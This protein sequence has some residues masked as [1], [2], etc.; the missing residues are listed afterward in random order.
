MKAQ[1]RNCFTNMERQDLQASSAN[2]KKDI[3]LSLKRNLGFWHKKKFLKSESQENYQITNYSFI[4]GFLTP[5]YQLDSW[6]RYPSEPLLM[7]CI[8]FKRSVL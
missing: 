1:L 6:F 2:S 4:R 7:I 5:T 3:E 8:N